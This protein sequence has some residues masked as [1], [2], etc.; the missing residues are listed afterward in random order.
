MARRG[1]DT[2]QILSGSRVEMD[3]TTAANGRDTTPSSG[4]VVEF[5]RGTIIDRYVVLGRLG[6]G[7]MGV[8]YVAYDP[9][10]DRKVA[11]KLVRAERSQSGSSGEARTRM[12]REAQ[13]LARLSHGNVV[14]VYDVGAVDED[15]WL[16]MELV[17]GQTL[18]AWCAQAR[19]WREVLNVL[20]AA[21]R[22]LEAAHQ[23][24]L[25]HRDFKPDNVM[26][27]GDGRVRVMDLGLARWAGEH[28]RPT[29]DMTEPLGK[30]TDVRPELAALA[31]RVTQAGSLIGTPFYMA[32]EQFEGKDA[33]SAA[34]IFAFCVTAWE[35]LHGER[36]FAGEKFLDLLANV[37]SGRPRPPPKGR[38]VPTWVR[39]ILE[40]GLLRDPTARWPS[41]AALLAA[42]A[43][44]PI[45]VRRQVLAIGVAV[46]GMTAIGYGVATVRNDEASMCRS[47]AAELSTVWNPHRMGEI[48]QAVRGTGVEYAGRALDH[49]TEHLD[50]YAARWITAH[51]ES[52]EAHRRGNVSDALFDRKMACLRQRRVEL[53]ATVSVLAQTTRATVGQLM[54]TAMGL[55]AVA[56][57]EDD[58]RLLADVAPPADPDTARA[59]EQARERLARLQAMERS[60]QFVQ[61]LGDVLALI[62]DSET[63]A[64][65]PL[66]VEAQLLAGT[67]YMHTFDMER[68]LASLDA[69]I[70]AGIEARTD[71]LVADALN[72]RMFVLS[73]IGR[74]LDALEVAPIAR[75]FVER[76]G[77]PPELD[78]NY[79]NCLGTAYA[80]IG[81]QSKAI[82]EAQA[83]ITILVAH[84]PDNPLRWA[85]VNNL[86]LALSLTDQR[87]KAGQMLRD[88]ISALEDRY[89]CHPHFEALRSEYAWYQFHQ[90]RAAESIANFNRALGC[91]GDEYPQFSIYAS[92]GLTRIGLLSGN[93]SEARRH[94]ARA[95]NFLAR[96]NM[97][98][99]IDWPT[100]ELELLHFDVE[101]ADGQPQEA[102]RSL[103][104]MRS[105]G[106]AL[107]EPYRFS[108]ETRLGLLA[109]R[110]N[111]HNRALEHFARAR[112][113]LPK[114]PSRTERGLYF[115]GL[116]RS[117]RASKRDPSEV[118]AEA[119]R[120]IEEYGAAGAAYS[121]RV[122]EVRAWLAELPLSPR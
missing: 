2:I 5:V 18:A 26:V 66:L 79:H 15:V 21:G 6:A 77:S 13:A 24:G 97:T 92:I 89:I 57:C 46:V 83:S 115:H 56:L 8:V 47:A 103:N 20:I 43:H 9:E 87:D 44:D 116:A 91:W 63:L 7:G 53:D 119:L 58:A 88:T 41:M 109:Q 3:A 78:A 48:E 33:G 84:A 108:F 93:I 23:A 70:A 60:G 16:A 28:E 81:D 105:Q 74:A 31:M 39:R 90:G 54:E 59:V 25:V 40:R 122:A 121:D 69:A 68:A 85:A 101:L 102:L 38:R 76:V 36:P 94:I 112:T 52:C 73:Q 111:D 106:D 86:T 19:P 65:P 72:K 117:L 10:L 35:A 100:T 49:A 34:D 118:R 27:G 55:P 50:A 82:V 99:K 64:Y 67:L 12:V 14:A 114:N 75:A 98:T 110:S 51:N 95:E 29:V 61:A 22:G 17:E 107:D 30:E 104:A 4:A 45:R 11:I 32:P 113:L 42:L 62:K 71:E 96:I 80:V 1:T 120:A 37:V